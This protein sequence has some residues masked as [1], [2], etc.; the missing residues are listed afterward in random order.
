MAINRRLGRL[1]RHL[2]PSAPAAAA[3]PPTGGVAAD[4]GWRDN[5]TGAVSPSGGLDFFHEQGYVVV[6]SVVPIPLIERL[7]AEIGEF[8]D[9]DFDRRE[10]WYKGGAAYTHS[11]YGITT[12][13]VELY[14][15]PGQWELRQ[16]PA[17]HE[18]FAALWGRRDLTI[19][20]DRAF[21]KP[22]VNPELNAALGESASL[23]E[24]LAG[25]WGEELGLHWDLGPPLPPQAE[26][27][28]QGQVLL[29]DVH[30]D[31]G[32]LT[33]VPG[34]IQRYDEFVSRLPTR[35]YPPNL[36]TQHSPRQSF[37]K[38]VL[39]D[40]IPVPVCGKRG[41]LVIWHG[42]TP[43][44][45]GRNTSEHVR[46]AQIMG[47]NPRDADDDEATITAAAA[48]HRRWMEQRICHDNMAAW[49]KQLVDEAPAHRRHPVATLTEHGRRLIGEL[50]W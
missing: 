4:F 21:I 28:L 1:A 6:P 42:H 49:Q 37:C 45:S 24:G 46:M 2:S 33:V 16:H 14:Q 50:P 48:A 3:G 47:M 34:F 7:V 5:A 43:H 29:S 9:I 35:D 23:A 36:G 17:V 22:P 40:E 25:G 41:D 31:S 38:E 15:A 39:R 30:P 13:S 8:L 12:G 32:G 18:V 26:L 10:Q 27:R 20:P 44:G 11:V 19:S